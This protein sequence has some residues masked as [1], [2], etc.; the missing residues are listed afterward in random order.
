MNNNLGLKSSN[1]HNV[2]RFVSQEQTL[3]RC[4]ILTVLIIPML[5]GYTP[6]LL[7]NHTKVGQVIPYLLSNH[8]G[9]VKYNLTN[10][11]MISTVI[12]QSD[13]LWYD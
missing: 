13:Q 6:Y 4:T 3:S 11:G 8:T 10:F 9:H 1:E 12:G 7:S 2:I 5:S